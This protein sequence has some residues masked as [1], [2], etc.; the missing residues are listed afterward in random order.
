MLKV[1]VSIVYKLII[2]KLSVKPQ[3]FKTETELYIGILLLHG[4]IYA[5]AIT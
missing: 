5:Y 2:D 3:Y 1:Y 4:H